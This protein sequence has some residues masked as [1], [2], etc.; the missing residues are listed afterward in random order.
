[1]NLKRD[2]SRTVVGLAILLIPILAFGQFRIENETRSNLSINFENPSFDIK[3]EMIGAAEYD[4]VSSESLTVTVDVGS[5]ELPFYSATIEMPNSGSATINVRIIE[6]TQIKD[7]NIKPFREN[8]LE[9]LT[10][11]NQVYSKNV[12]YPAEIVQIGEPAIFRNKRVVSFT[13]HPFRY[14]DAINVLE[15]I[16]KAEIE[17]SFDN[18]PSVNEI[19]RSK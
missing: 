17:I 5:P 19:T 11:N 13:I 12:F 16:E 7:V 14:N 3:Q 9:L 8:D 4:Y 10:F 1:M 15:V 18:T 2:F 6:S